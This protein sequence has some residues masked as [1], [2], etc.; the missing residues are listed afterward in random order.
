MS[1]A[2]RAEYRNR[3]LDRLGRIMAEETR[4]IRVPLGDAWEEIA[5]AESMLHEAGEAYVSEEID[6]DELDHKATGFLRFWRE[7]VRI[8]TAR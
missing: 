3:L 2:V 1:A 7:T 5:L 4:D 6:K 8:H